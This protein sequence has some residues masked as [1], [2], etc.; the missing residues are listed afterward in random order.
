MKDEVRIFLM[1][2]TGE[3]KEQFSNSA[4]KTKLTGEPTAEIF[5]DQDSSKHKMF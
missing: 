1:C 3:L 4:V 5:P 2:I